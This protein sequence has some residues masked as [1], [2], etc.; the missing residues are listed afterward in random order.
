MVKSETMLMYNIILLLII[1][2]R[3]YSK[4]YD[5]LLHEFDIIGLQLLWAVKDILNIQL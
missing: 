4:L 5:K 1:Y 3:S 2:F